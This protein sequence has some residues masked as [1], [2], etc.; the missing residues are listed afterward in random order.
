M[1][2]SHVHAKVLELARIEYVDFDVEFDPG[3][4]VFPK[5]AALFYVAAYVLAPGHE[6]D[7]I[8]P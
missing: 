5:W 6:L 2:I 7:S 8:F 4:G 3:I 1:G